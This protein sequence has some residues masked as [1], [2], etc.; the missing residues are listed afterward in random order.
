MSHLHGVRA[1]LDVLCIT[2]SAARNFGPTNF[3]EVM[4]MTQHREILRLHSQGISQR[5]IAKSCECSR[6]TVT[7]TDTLERAEALGIVWQEI[8]G[9]SDQELLPLLFPEQ[10]VPLE[11][12]M[13]DFEYIHKEMAKSCSEAPKDQI[14]IQKPAM[15]GT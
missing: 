1:I 11:R 14:I 7:N 12:R 15:V 9:L 8:Q 2:E 4:L 6:N 10:A 13:P 5:N 3:K